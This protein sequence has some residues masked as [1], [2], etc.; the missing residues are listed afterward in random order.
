VACSIAILWVEE[1]QVVRKI[2]AMTALFLTLSWPLAAWSGRAMLAKPYSRLLWVLFAVFW[3]VY[4]V[5][6]LMLNG[7]LNIDIESHPAVLL[8]LSGLVVFSLGVVGVDSRIGKDAAIRLQRELD[9]REEAEQQ[10]MLSRQR[11]E[12]ARLKA[13]VERQTRRCARPASRPR[14]AARPSHASCP[15]PAM[16]CG[17]RCTTCWATRS[18][19]PARSHPRPRGTWR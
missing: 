18:C 8:Y 19:S 3:V 10:R 4:A 5:R 15:A 2:A 1:H 7:L 16:S 17:R 12:A 9:S 6:V 14:P 11:E 13:E